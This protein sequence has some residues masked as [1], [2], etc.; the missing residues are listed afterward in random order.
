MEIKI[1]F[2]NWSKERLNS[3]LKLATTRNKRYGKIG[4][5]FS[6]DI[7]H[8]KYTFEILA[9]FQLTLYYVA[10]D[11]YA[12]EGADSP[13]EFRKVWEEIHPKLGWTPDKKVFVHLFRLTEVS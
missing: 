5:T 10:K 12:I 8:R 4:D 3:K 13:L 6:V 2:N 1:P 7:K 9:V 11:L